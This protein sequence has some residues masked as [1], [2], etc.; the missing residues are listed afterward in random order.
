VRP[1]RGS[2]LIEIVISGLVLFVGGL[3]ILRTFAPSYRYATLTEHQ[4]QAHRLGL[5]ILAQLQSVPSSDRKGL[6]Q[7]RHFKVSLQGLN[8][9]TPTTVTYQVREISFRYGGGMPAT[10]RT[11]DVATV[12]IAWNDS[13]LAVSGNVP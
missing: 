3:A 10:E 13:Q 7:L 1:N 6:D 8:E 2:L 11:G 5:G 9:G 4:L 12:V